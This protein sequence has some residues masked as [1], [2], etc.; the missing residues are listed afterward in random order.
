[1]D[2]NIISHHFECEGR[3]QKLAVR[4]KDRHMIDIK[5]VFGLSETKEAE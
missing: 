1:M 3:R 5:S 4:F 2:V